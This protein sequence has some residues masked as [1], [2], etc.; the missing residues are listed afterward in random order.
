[1]GFKRLKR[2][3]DFF[4]N[5]CYCCH[6][7]K[8]LLMPLWDDELSEEILL[9]DLSDLSDFDVEVITDDYL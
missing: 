4:Y 2:L 5:C 7:K 9:D 3:K 8:T 6:R 1:M